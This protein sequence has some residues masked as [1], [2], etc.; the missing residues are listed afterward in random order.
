MDCRMSLI[1][2]LC[3]GLGGIG[4]QTTTSRVASGPDAHAPSGAVVAK[5]KEGPRKLKPETKVLMA[6]AFLDQSDD[7]TKVSPEVQIKLRDQA[8][9]AYQEAI[10]DDPNHIPAYRGLAKVYTK[11]NEMDKA[12]ETMHTA[13][14]LEPKSGQLWADLA[15]CHNCRKE[16]DQAVQCFN[17][18]MELE[19]QDHSL[20]RL[21]GFTLA[22][23]GRTEESVTLLTK[24]YGAE[25][26]HFHVAR[27]MIEMRQYDAA[28]VQLD[29]TL[30]ANPNHLDAQ[31]MLYRLESMNDA[32]SPVAAAVPAMP[33]TE[34]QP[35]VRSSSE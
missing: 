30:R 25:Y 15:M 17:K 13:I 29:L 27:M 20:P 1:V 22:R 31:L 26:A 35:T 8:R 28:K 16:Y 18:A 12:L 24:H 14:K 7:L 34:P 21:L 5:P 9:V 10:K 3:L 23:A 4:C 33:V 19:P 32:Q 11:L 2:A 6:K